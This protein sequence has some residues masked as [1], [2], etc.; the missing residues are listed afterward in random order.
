MLASG[1]LRWPVGHFQLSFPPFL[2]PL[3]TPL[4]MRHFFAFIKNVWITTVE[5]TLVYLLAETILSHSCYWLYAK[6]KGSFLNVKTN[7]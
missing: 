6:S 2:K 1:P 3:V 5:K 4:A 7:A